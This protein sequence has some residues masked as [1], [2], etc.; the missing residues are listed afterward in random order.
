MLKRLN[1]ELRQDTNTEEKGGT[2][3]WH[4]ELD[5][6]RQQQDS[7][8]YLVSLNYCL[9]VCTGTSER[10]ALKRNQEENDNL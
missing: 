10:K 1:C 2:S 9:A 6:G 7:I 3:T 4:T 5:K 8:A